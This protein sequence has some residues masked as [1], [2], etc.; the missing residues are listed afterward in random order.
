MTEVLDAAGIGDL[1]AVTV[2]GIDLDELGLPGKPDPAM[3]VE[4]ARRLGVD[5]SS[6][7]V[8]EDALAGVE[9]GTRGGI[10]F[11]VGVDRTGHADA[12]RAAGADVVVSDLAEL[13]LPPSRRTFETSRRRSNAAARSERCSRAGA[14][15]CSSTTTGRS[16]R[17]SSVPRTRCCRR[18]PAPRSSGWPR[19]LRWR[20]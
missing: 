1:F 2:D 20:S 5:P 18:R 17:S 13:R 4:A 9:A 6:A 12:L 3:F 7:A 14:W 11:V 19:S 15:P 16:R 10:G 8:V